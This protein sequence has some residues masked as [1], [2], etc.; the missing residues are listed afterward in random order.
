MH[1]SVPV[2]L[3]LLGLLACSRSAAGPVPGALSACI[4]GCAALRSSACLEERQP[5]LI[6]QQMRRLAQW[7]LAKEDPQ[8]SFLKSVPASAASVDI[9][10]PVRPLPGWRI[11]RVA[12]SG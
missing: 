8:E 9:I 7:V 3:V 5:G 1:C 2:P 4:C 12:C 6:R 10:Y 11:G